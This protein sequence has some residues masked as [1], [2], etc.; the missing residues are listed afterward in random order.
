MALQEH[1]MLSNKVS[2]DGMQAHAQYGARDK[3]HDWF[4][5]PGIVDKNV[6]CK[7]H[8]CIHHLQFGH[9][10]WVHHQRPQCIEKGLEEEPEHFSCRC[11]EEPAFQLCRD[12]HVQAVSAEVAVVVDVVFLEGGGVGKADGQIGEHGEPPVP[13]HLLVP[14]CNVVRD[15]MDGQ[16]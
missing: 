7:L 12:V 11:A 8:G 9:R 13:A 5:S 3:V 14:E 15:V 1:V 6:C 16:G 4:E 2:R 10:F